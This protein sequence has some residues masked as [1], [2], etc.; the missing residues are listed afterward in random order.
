MCRGFKRGLCELAVSGV[1]MSVH[2]PAENARLSEFCSPFPRVLSFY[3]MPSFFSFR[4]AVHSCRSS[5]K[6]FFPFF[7]SQGMEISRLRGIGWRSPS[8]FHSTP[9][10]RTERT[11]T[12]HTPTT[13]TILKAL[14]VTP[15]PSKLPL[16]S[17]LFLLFLLLLLPHHLLLLLHRPR[18]LPLLPLLLSLRETRRFSGGRSIIL[19]SALSWRVSF[20]SFPSSLILLP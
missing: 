16:L 4:H 14:A 10:T 2:N 7:F 3:K 20:L 1:S 19:L 15:A 9:G 17:P 18:R 6:S 8:I 13:K 11:S 5:W 12:P